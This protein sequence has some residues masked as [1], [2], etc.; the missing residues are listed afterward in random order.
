MWRQQKTASSLKTVFINCTA[1]QRRDSEERSDIS[2]V[3]SAGGKRTNKDAEEEQ[4]SETLG[5]ASLSTGISLFSLRDSNTV[6]T[7]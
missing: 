7:R 4:T 3:M 5:W 2:P 1:E 6:D